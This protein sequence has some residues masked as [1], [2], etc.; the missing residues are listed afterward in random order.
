MQSKHKITV[1][2]TITI[3]DFSYKGNLDGDDIVEAICASVE[4]PNDE[5]LYVL[6]PLL[7]RVGSESGK[8]ENFIW[9]IVSITI[10]FTGFFMILA[11][12]YKNIIRKEID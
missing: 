3:N 9:I 10:G 6:D 11:W 5:C 4:Q 7:V 12:V 8:N 1:W 2:P